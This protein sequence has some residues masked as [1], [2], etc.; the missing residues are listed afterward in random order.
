MIEEILT[1]Y[2]DGLKLEGV[3]RY[4]DKT[5]TP[6]PVILLIHGSL[7]HDRDG[8]LLKTKDEKQVYSKN[9]FKTILDELPD[10]AKIII[11]FS[12]ED[13]PVAAAFIIHYKRMM[14]IPW[15]ATLRKY[16]RLSP[17]MLLYF[18]VLKYAIKQQC[19]LFDFGRCTKDS[20]T[21]RFKKQWGGEEKV[22]YWYYM[23]K[24]NQEI[25]EVNPNN[26]KYQMAIRVWKKLPLF[27]TKMVGP[28]IVKNIP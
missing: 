26:P 5:I 15:A 8:N 22:L 20:G 2:S 21:Y 11:I 23:L 3:L 16:D 18:E 4:P 1:F 7:E 25:P 9:F 10:N 24:P 12:K 13:I 14:E 28:S 19:S 6:I 17:N 27:L